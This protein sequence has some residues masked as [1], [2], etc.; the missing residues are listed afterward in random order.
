MPNTRPYTP[1]TQTLFWLS[2]T[3][4][5]SAIPMLISCRPSGWP[6]SSKF[7]RIVSSVNDLYAL[8]MST[9]Y[10]S[11]SS[12]VWLADTCSLSGWNLTLSFL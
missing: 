1:R 10:D 7:F 11:I 8:V 5:G 3:Q 9:K 4:E 6:Y 2:M 12:F